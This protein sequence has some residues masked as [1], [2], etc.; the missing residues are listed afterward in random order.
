MD[1]NRLDIARKVGEEALNSDSGSEADEEDIEEQSETGAVDA[2]QV[3]A[4]RSHRY[5]NLSQKC[6]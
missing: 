3:T 6:L 5:N 1:P 2:N 4:T